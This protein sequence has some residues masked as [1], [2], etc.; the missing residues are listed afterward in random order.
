MD[1]QLW[2]PTNG[3]DLDDFTGDESATVT[4]TD[5]ENA[6]YTADSGLDIPLRPVHP[7]PIDPDPGC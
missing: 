5:S 2:Q 7:V 3:Q 1:G 4:L 6:I